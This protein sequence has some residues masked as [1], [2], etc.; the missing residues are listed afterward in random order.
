MRLHLRLLLALCSALLLAACGSQDAP[1]PPEDAPPASEDAPAPS[2]PESG[3]LTLR[4]PAKPDQRPAEPPKPLTP[5]LLILHGGDPLPE[6]WLKEWKGERNL[7]IQQRPLSA[8]ESTLPADAALILLPPHRLGPLAAQRP[9][10]PLNVHPPLA[11][12]LFLHHPYDPGQRVSL[13]FRWSPYVLY[14]RRETAEA[15]FPPFSI[16]WQPEEGILWPEPPAPVRAFWRKSQ[17]A[18]ANLPSEEKDLAAWQAI[19]SA[20]LP[21]LFSPA[22]AWAAFLEGKAARCWLPAAYRCRLPAEK[23]Q[24][25]TLDWIIPAFGTLIHLDLLAIPADSAQATAAAELAAFLTSPE[26]QQRLAPETGWLPVNQPLG[27]ETKPSPCP[28][29]GGDWLDKSE[30]PYPEQPFPIAPE[31]PK[32][33]SPQAPDP[34][35]QESEPDDK[36]SPAP[37]LPPEAISQ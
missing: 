20:L 10:L 5:R 31:S 26:L 12:P 15:A 9:L 33:A 11:S 25:G 35:P 4:P 8:S 16:S 14:R 27:K 18:S 13:P 30:I 17:G 22:S 37:L 23:R 21:A 36:E 7:T 28:L 1:P 32:E 29:P 19:E 24:D 6:E 3:F 34:E 2:K